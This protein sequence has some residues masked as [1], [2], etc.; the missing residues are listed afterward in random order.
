MRPL[1][2]KSSGPK[3]SPLFVVLDLGICFFSGR[4]LAFIP[5]MR[6]SPFSGSL[7]QSSSWARTKVWMGFVF[8]WPHSHLT[9]EAAWGRGPEF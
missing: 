7:R 8:R 4:A 9:A 1:M 2:G 5:S 6:Q 3:P